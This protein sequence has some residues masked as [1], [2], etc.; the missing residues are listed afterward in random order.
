VT[1]PGLA[2][3]V[4]ES[5]KENSFPLTWTVVLRA[6]ATWTSESAAIATTAS[7]DRERILNRLIENLRR[8]DGG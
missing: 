4:A 7:I 3:D 5:L 2:S 6:E 8:V 1:V